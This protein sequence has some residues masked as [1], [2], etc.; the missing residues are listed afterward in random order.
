MRTKEQ[1]CLKF[2]LYYEK[3]AEMVKAKRRAKYA[4]DPDKERE[5]CKLR[6]RQW[7]KQNPGHRNAL[8]AAYKADKIKATPKWVNLER[9]KALYQL[10]A[11]LNKNTEE[12]WHVDHII[13]LRN[14]HVCGLHTYENLQVITAKENM[15]KHNTYEVA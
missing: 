3:N 4:A 2:K 9:I 10:A 1:D 15:Q 8:K 7:R 14:S 12:K 11:M 5:A 13:P 6:S